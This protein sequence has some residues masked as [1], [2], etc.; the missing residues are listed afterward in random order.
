MQYFYMYNKTHKCHLYLIIDSL[1]AVKTYTFAYM[2]NVY[3]YG[4]MYKP[5]NVHFVIH[6]SLRNWLTLHIEDVYGY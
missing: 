1:I 2:Y 5:I 4:C 6:W 3:V